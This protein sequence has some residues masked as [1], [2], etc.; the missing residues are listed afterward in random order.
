MDEDMSQIKYDFINKVELLP[1]TSFLMVLQ[2]WSVLD[3]LLYT[4]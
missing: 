1:S 3:L 4:L 2:Y